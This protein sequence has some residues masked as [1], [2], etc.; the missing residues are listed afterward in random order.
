MT[1]LQLFLSNYEIQKMYT[2]DGKRFSIDVTSITTLSDYSTLVG[3]TT[4]V[5]ILGH[6]KRHVN[7]TID[8]AV[9]NSGV[10]SITF[11]IS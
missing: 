8:T 5:H 6:H 9:N 1:D 7:L 3:Q 4:S 11:A 10:I 2:T